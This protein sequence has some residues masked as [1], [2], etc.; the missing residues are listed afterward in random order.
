MMPLSL[1]VSDL[2]ITSDRG[3][4]LL[5]VPHLTA[6]P[7]EAIGIR[8][9]SGAGKST[10]LL[11]L[12]GLLDHAQGRVIWGQDDLLA[13]G[14]ARRAAFRARHMGLIFQDFMLFE[15]LGPLAN[16][17]VTALF[18]PRGERAGLRARAR[19]HLD[20]LRVPQ[21]ARDVTSFSGG[22]RQRI[23][24]ARALANDAQ[25]LLADEPTASLDRATAD[26]LITDLV[27]MTRESGKTLIAV[28]HDQDLLDRMD[29]VITVSDGQI[30]E[31]Q[32]A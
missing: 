26:A 2:V 11:A 25:I 7:G 31:A 32:D 4:R 10:L 27:A 29:R 5:S 8:G 28:S 9:P 22:E 3:R 13:M 1:T 19:A 12:A 21:A 17:S 6:T 24:V 23:A 16:A 30:Q 18:R 14:D 20:R 15:E